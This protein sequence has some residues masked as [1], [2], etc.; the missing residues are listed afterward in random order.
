M[1][2]TEEEAKT[3]YD[4]QVAEQQPK[5]E[6]DSANYATYNSSSV[7]VVRP[8]NSKYVKNLLLQIPSDVQ[9]EIRQLRTDGDDAGADVKRDEALA[10]IKSKADAALAR[11]KAGE[12]FDALIEELGE[13][14]GMKS[15]PAKT[16]GYLV[17]KGSGMV[18][19]FEDASLALANPGDISDLVASDYGYHIIQNVRNAGGVI[20]FDEIKDDI[21]KKKLAEAQS[22]HLTEKLTEWEDAA[23]IKTDASK[24]G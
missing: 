3:F 20:P 13:D 8:E 4:E 11:A 7:A 14:S 24:L 1:T 5:V 22:A 18:Q 6:E 12:D 19:P 2:Y 23:D 9:T 17:Y 16:E 21:I 15:E 10:E